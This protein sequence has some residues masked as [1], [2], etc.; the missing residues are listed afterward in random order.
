MSTDSRP[1]KSFWQALWSLFDP[2]ERYLRGISPQVTAIAA[3]EAEFEQLSQQDL[4]DRLLRIRARVEETRKNTLAQQAT[5]PPAE[6]SDA[7]RKRQKDLIAAEKAVLDAALPEV[8]AAVR[9]AAKRTLSMRH[10]DV[11]ILGGIVL[12]EG[13]IAE[14]KTGEGK[15]LT[16]TC[17]LVLNALAGRGAHVVTV[18]DY[19][20]RR[21]AEW[22]GKIYRYLG[23]TVGVIQHDL[24]REERQH[25]Y[26][27]DITYITNHE[28]GF[29]YLRDHSSA[30][31]PE[32]LVIRELHYAIIDEVDSILIDEARV[33]L[34][35]AGNRGK[36]VE[37][38]RKIQEITARLQQG[39]YDEETREATGDFWIDE[40]AKN[41]TITEDGQRKVEIALG[42]DNLN[43][44]AHI[45]D[46]HLVGAALKA[47]F[48]YKRDID[49]IV[50]PG[51]GG[52]ISV[53]IVDTFT[54]R[55]QPGRRWSDGL[56]QAIEAKEKVA[57]QDEQ[58]TIATVTYQNFFLMYHRLS[59]MTGTAKTE[60]PEFVGIYEMPVV[61]VPTNRPMRRTEHPDIVY[62][63]EEWKF[64]GIC[65]EIVQLFTRRQPVLVGTRSVE[66]S[67]RLSARL[68]PDKLR[69]TLQLALLQ[70]HIMEHEK[71]LDKALLANLRQVTAV[72]LEALK[73]REVAEFLRSLNLDGEL[74]KP[75]V[76]DRLLEILEVEDAAALRDVLQHGVPH[77]VL[78]ARHHEREA[79]IVAQAGRLG[80]V[81]IA[82]NMAGRGTDIVLGGNPEPD[83]E[84]LLIHRGID[85]KS[86]QA[87]LFM[88]QALKG[89]SAAAAAMATAQG[90]LPH[91]VQAE[92]AAIRAAWRSEQEDVL[93]TGGLH[94]LG[95]ERHESRRIDNQLR[96]RSGRQGDPGSSRFYVSL[97][98]ELMRL[99]GPERWGMLMNQW[100]EEQ[101]VEAR[102]ISKAM[103]NAQRKVESRNFDM[104]KNTLRYDDVMNVQRLHIYAERRRIL[105][106]V[107]LRQTV[108]SMIGAMVEETTNTTV[109]SE[110]RADWALT[111]LWNQLNQRFPLKDQ[112]R[113]EEL[114]G[115]SRESLVAHLRAAAERAYDDKEN[116]FVR[117]VVNYELQA[118]IHETLQQVPDRDV[119]CQVLNAF[120]PLAEYLPARLSGLPDGKVPETLLAVAAEALEAAPRQFLAAVVRER[121]GRALAAAGER[122]AAGEPAAAVLAGLAARWPL[123][124]SAGS[125]EGLAPDAAIAVL[126]G[127]LTAALDKDGWG[128]TTAALGRH[129]GALV[130]EVLPRCCDLPALVA[131]I[132]R[133]WPLGEGFSV[134]QLQASNY[135]VIAD[136]LHRLAD[137]RL[138]GGGQAFIGA[139]AEH[140]LQVACDTPGDRASNVGEVLPRTVVLRDIDWERDRAELAEQLYDAAFDQVILEAVEAA[141]VQA[142][143]A[144]HRQLAAGAEGEGEDEE[145]LAAGDLIKLVERLNGQWAFGQALD[146]WELERVPAGEVRRELSIKVRDHVRIRG[147]ALV[148]ETARLRWQA[149]LDEAVTAHYSVVGV[150]AK[151]AQTLEAA[152]TFEPGDYA[153]LGDV[154]E[155]TAALTATANEAFEEDPER[156]SAFMRLLPG[157]LAEG[158]NPRRLCDRLN[159]ELQPTRRLTPQDLADVTAEELP[160]RLHELLAEVEQAYEDRFALDC[161]R[162]HLN[163]SIDDAL[164]RFYDLR[165]LSSEIA[166]AWPI[167]SD[168]VR[169]SK[170]KGWN[171]DELGRRLKEVLGESYRWEQWRYHRRFAQMLLRDGLLEAAE[172]YAPATL[173][174][175]EWDLAGLCGELAERWAEFATP[176]PADLPLD[177]R[178]RLL[179]VALDWA[180]RAYGEQERA[181]VR[182]TAR[183]R[184][185]NQVLLLRREH[186]SL[187]A[188]AGRVNQRW[189]LQKTVQ[190]LQMAELRELLDRPALFES[191][192]ESLIEPVLATAEAAF[193]A[194]ATER[195]LAASVDEVLAARLN[196]EKL[197]E[198]LIGRWPASFEALQLSALEGLPYRDLVER[199]RRSLAT[200]GPALQRRLVFHAL[201]ETVR[202]QLATLDGPADT[203]PVAAL[204][205]RLNAALPGSNL[206][207]PAAV[208]GELLGAA[209]GDDLHA[210]A[211]AAAAAGE[212][213]AAVVERQ[214]RAQI[215]A[216]MEQEKRPNAL[217][218]RLAAHWPVA[219]RLD[220]NALRGATGS[221]LKEAL[222]GA[223]QAAWQAGPQAFVA[224][225]SELWAAR[226]VR[227]ALEQYWP[228][229]VT[230]PGP[231]VMAQVTAQLNQRW[232]T[233]ELLHPSNYKRFE[234]EQLE[235]ALRAAAAELDASSAFVAE[236]VRLDGLAELQRAARQAVGQG[237][238]S[239][240]LAALNPVLLQLWPDGSLAVPR[241]RELLTTDLLRAQLLAQVERLEPRLVSEFETEPV[242]GWLLRRLD[243]N[244]EQHG[245][246]QAVA[247]QLTTLWPV[248]EVDANRLGGAT[249]E[250]IRQAFIDGLV[251][252]S[253]RG[254]ANFING[255]ARLQLPP[256]GTADEAK[257]E[258]RFLHQTVQQ[259]LVDAVA[260]AQREHANP[261]IAAERWDLPAFVAVLERDWPVTGQLAS[262][263]GGNA[264]QVRQAAE[265]VLLGAYQRDSVTFLRDTVRQQ[266]GSSVRDALAEHASLAR[267]AEVLSAAWPVAGTTFDAA[268]LESAQ[269]AELEPTVARWMEEVLG[270]D[271]NRADA[272]AAEFM[273]SISATDLPAVCG[274]LAAQHTE[275]PALAPA[276]LAEM[277]CEEVLKTRLWE[278]F[279]AD[280]RAFVKAVALEDVPRQLER[281][282]M[283]EAIDTN[284]CDHLEAMDYLREGIG[285]RGYAQT[286][287]FIAYRKDGRQMFENMLHRVRETVVAGLFETTEQQLVDMHA[288]GRLG[289]R[290]A[291]EFDNVQEVAAK[292]EDLTASQTPSPAASAVARP[293]AAAGGVS[294]GERR[295]GAPAPAA[296]RTPVKV[297]KVGRNDLCPCGS[298]KKYKQCCGRGT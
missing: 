124:L 165:T 77:E 13:R 4:R 296:Q 268:T 207:Q 11:Q 257:L 111:D 230:E 82:T 119:V 203:W 156:L 253:R 134:E 32:H 101:P 120:W 172:E 228:S 148:A 162:Q 12:H 38:Y 248:G 255:A 91:P 125:L 237:D 278:D 143:E 116:D 281:R 251:D 208:A 259:R 249:Y 147:R 22:M 138:A 104:R 144:A 152:G 294:G 68:R 231:W 19:L 133:L 129:M 256:G 109:G 184:F 287:P 157:L 94:I 199:L 56:H 264:A 106:G 76:F 232:N 73:P 64:R 118:N 93:A 279:Q 250:Q 189:Q 23:L 293:R 66:T 25:A 280:P 181:F 174:P 102:I 224:A 169:P 205:E 200:A 78:N 266:L 273:A 84:D 110:S 99:F 160:S 146:A 51:D 242:Q 52:V 159:L 215:D 39:E 48:C 65:C 267:L 252:A 69:L 164:D 29:D 220:P 211:S 44:S 180:R 246:L 167:N 185:E 217:A 186:F 54:G 182:E 227:E 216:W 225:A 92:I 140:R 145:E 35:I 271:A 114:Q 49:Y 163:Q 151:L 191:A 43:D 17:P 50:G 236:L 98:D 61:V 70:A 247:R 177:S 261:E 298:K 95:T 67:E 284:W 26:G 45:E 81:T 198:G 197:V 59:G 154:A 130:D 218:E 254:G 5:L 223:V 245:S 288:H 135:G 219:G 131:A 265:R 6:D 258:R 14:M 112:V 126:T 40:K 121:V 161:V 173:P 286:D 155:L 31:R 222:R 295:P 178:E 100:P 10:F 142:A 289:L 153:D 105:E 238:A 170:L 274:A 270:Y 201:R 158:Y 269:A 83:V 188:A 117:S 79:Q 226:C 7:R 209:L 33:P 290:I 103:S 53:I 229:N 192:M 88:N 213:L 9:E 97:Q 285:L 241:L 16:A 20:A 149:L 46:M 85:P 234:R 171:S 283:L 244:L 190:P 175:A 221:P 24:S 115:Q 34:I 275:V 128:F 89:E 1:R 42:I 276:G 36:P 297:D 62:K 210:A 202:E 141:A 123:R 87:T 235:T 214:A 75:E 58:Q 72:P 212:R 183:H 243:A 282:L 2:N 139:A 18:N 90:G 239:F 80:A 21:D 193:L 27:C 168:T 8:F 260:E 196:V 277:L 195:R 240:A 57:I 30:W 96:G 132:A 74:E 28:I 108:S 150:C 107:D 176:Q 204:I 113:F 15:T 63:S 194:D 60:E 166:A 233:P 86:L 127:E 263:G 179:D 292:A 262:V 272:A 122:L 41:A 136:R 71:K 47:N 137:Q 187:S 291:I 37:R 55:P 3:L 206:L